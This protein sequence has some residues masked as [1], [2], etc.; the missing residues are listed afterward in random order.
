MNEG[1]K[2]KYGDGEKEE[3]KSMKNMSPE[4]IKKIREELKSQFGEIG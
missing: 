3:T 4:Q 2:Q 1:I